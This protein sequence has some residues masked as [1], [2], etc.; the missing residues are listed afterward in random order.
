MIR[1]LRRAIL[2]LLIALP[3]I[4]INA[5]EQG[6]SLDIIGITSTDL[7]QVAIHASILD[8]SGQLVSGP[9]GG[10]LLHQRGLGALCPGDGRGE[11]HR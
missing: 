7:S 2:A 1:R 4:V 9:G 6:I 8:S 5:Q 10:E 3:F 11:C